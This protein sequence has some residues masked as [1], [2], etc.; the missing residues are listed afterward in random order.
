MKTVSL[1]LKAINYKLIEHNNKGKKSYSSGLRIDDDSQ[2]WW[3]CLEAKI[4]QLSI[5]PWGKLSKPPKPEDFVP[6]KTNKKGYSNIYDKIYE[7]SCKF[8]LLVEDGHDLI[9]LKELTGEE[10]YGCCILNIKRLFIG[11]KKCYCCGYERISCRNKI[12]T[13][14][15]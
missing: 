14:L 10:W 12:K 4:Q 2:E 9:P 5:P 8:A 1:K 3:E 6:I 7:N 11:T 13:I 15:F